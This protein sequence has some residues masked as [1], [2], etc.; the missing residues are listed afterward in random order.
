[1]TRRS[2]ESTVAFGPDPMINPF[3]LPALWK[4][5]RRFSLTFSVVFASALLG[6]PV[7]GLLRRA[8]GE[9]SLHWLLLWLVPMVLVGLLARYEHLLIRDGDL[10]RRIAIGVLLFAAAATFVLGRLRR[11]MAELRPPPTAREAPG[12]REPLS[13]EPEGGPEPERAPRRGPRSK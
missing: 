8:L 9:L 6:F 13:R 10:R 11:Q 5:L 1:M 12:E 2:G 3:D 7:S 4:A